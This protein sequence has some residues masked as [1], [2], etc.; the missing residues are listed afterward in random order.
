M[1]ISPDKFKGTMTAPAAALAIAEGV[2]IAEPTSVISLCPVADGGEGTLGTLLDA[3]GGNKRFVTS[4]DPW[5][6]AARPAVAVLDDGTICI[7]SAAKSY[8]DPLRAD[9]FGLGVVIET[10]MA[11]QAASRLLV[12]IGGTASTDG[13]TGLA[14]ALGWRFLDEAGHDLP[15][16]GGALADLHRVVPPQDPLTIEIAGL[17]DVDAPLTGAD[18]SAE[19]FAP[20][21]GASPDQVSL[22]E[23]GLRRLVEVVAADVGIDL[24]RVPG[25]GAGGGIA[26]GLVAFCG[27]RLAPGFEAVADAVRLRPRIQAADL[28]ITG[29]GRFDEQSL[30][31]KA[32][33]GV[34]RLSHEEGVP[35]LG[36]FGAIS[37]SMNDTLKAGFSD[38]MTLP[39]Q[40]TH[41]RD[42]PETLSRAATMMMSRQPA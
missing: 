15:P 29:E 10:L 19:R 40:P 31:G 5:G 22:L 16:G 6:H 33:A 36:I 41:L 39:T 35:C 28:V 13:G 34:A 17:Y 2:R 42:A 20:Q 9:S 25:A 21:K 38:V 30:Q 26:A 27:G 37:T 23:R 12:A 8:G 24:D 1:L 4:L 3:I 14:R 11:E 7:E 32:A 18:G